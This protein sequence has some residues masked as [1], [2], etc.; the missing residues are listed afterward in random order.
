MK[1][2]RLTIGAIIVFVFVS[3]SYACGPEFDSAYLVRASKE[4]FLAIPE[5]NFL[6]ELSRISGKKV[7]FD[8]AIPVPLDKGKDS[9]V[10]ADAKDLENALTSLNLKKEDNSQ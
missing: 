1:I 6:F 7:G 8:R 2:F 4:E 10:D 3:Y 5:G 9:T